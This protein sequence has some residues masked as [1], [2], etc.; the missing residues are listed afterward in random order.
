MQINIPIVLTPLIL[1]LHPP[2]IRETQILFNPCV[3]CSWFAEAI[4][5]AHCYECRETPKLQFLF[6][7]DLAYY[8][9]QKGADTCAKPQKA[10]YN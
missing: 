6:P 5:P 9:N 7:K 1:I 10:Q 8:I 4:I 2:L 3:M